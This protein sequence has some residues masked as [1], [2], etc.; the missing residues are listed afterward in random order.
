MKKAYVILLLCAS[1]F[2]HACSNAKKV[3]KERNGVHARGVDNG[4]QAD[5]PPR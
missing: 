2:V 5:M 3:T 4:G 1:V